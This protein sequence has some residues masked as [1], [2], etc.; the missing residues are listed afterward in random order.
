MPSTWNTIRIFI[1]STFRDMHA[2]RDYLVKVVFPELRERCAKR[3]LNL[4]DVDLRC[5]S[6]RS[7]I[8]GKYRN[9]RSS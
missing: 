7:L 1:S 3:H 4:I 2:E 9:W 8:E 5:P 6:F